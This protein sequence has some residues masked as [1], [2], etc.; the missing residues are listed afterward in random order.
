[1]SDKLMYLGRLLDL[2]E[3]GQSDYLI[4]LKN[5]LGFF[6]EVRR[7]YLEEEDRLCLIQKEE[8]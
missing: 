3:E 6:N 2:L 5:Y 4:S 8:G 7:Q 1:M